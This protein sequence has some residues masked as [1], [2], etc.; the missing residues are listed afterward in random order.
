MKKKISIALCIL[1]F[2]AFYAEASEQIRL[3]I[4]PFLS[5]SGEIK[6]NQTV[7]ITDMLIKTLQASPSISVIERER[8]RTIARGHGIN[9]ESEEQNSAMKLG[10]LVGCRYI[11]LGSATQLTQRYINSKKAVRFFLDTSYEDNIESQ[12]STATLEARLIDVNTGKV[13]LSFSKSGSVLLSKKDYKSLTDLTT[14]AIEAATSRLG[15]KIREILANEYAMIISVKGNN[16]RI[17]RG[18]S[19]GVNTGALYRVYQ[20]GE[21]VFDLDGRSLGKKMINLAIVRV[22]DTQS[23]FSTVEVFSSQT[24]EKKE[25]PQKKKSAKTKKSKKN[26]ANSVVNLIRQ[27]DKIEVVSFSEAEKLKLVTQRL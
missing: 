20:E 9:V 16:A 5:K 6:E 25:P 15:N 8:L 18:S 24:L 2:S 12:E 26:E 3:G 23:E 13:V 17:N 21:E 27:G 10:K 14:R 4:M 7:G 1:F 19:S 22:I 11:L